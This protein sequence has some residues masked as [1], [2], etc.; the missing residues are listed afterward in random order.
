M[1]SDGR[2]WLFPLETAGWKE[3]NCEFSL[4]DLAPMRV[5]GELVIKSDL[6]WLPREISLASRTDCCC[7]L[8][9]TLPEGLDDCVFVVFWEDSGWRSARLES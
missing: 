7:P 5:P 6:C 2:S 9:P 3:S 8:L 4:F 1:H